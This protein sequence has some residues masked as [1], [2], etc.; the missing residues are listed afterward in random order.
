MTLGDRSVLL[1]ADLL[2]GP[3][4]CGWR[5]VLATHSPLHRA[6]LYK[7][8]HHGA[9]NAHHDG[10][11][12]DLLNN[13]PLAVLAPYRAGARP[14]PDSADVGRLCGLSQDL[15]S[16]AAVSPVS[17]KRV[18][19]ASAALSSVASN[20]RE[21]TGAVGHVR[22]RAVAAGGWDVQIAGPARSLCSS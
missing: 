18:K 17:D 3:E 4:G 15:V 1:G 12:S 2:A 5:A 20:V 14:R 22:A 21:P 19:R 11:W 16:T 10:I 7:V 9:P 8:A 13:Q 6:D